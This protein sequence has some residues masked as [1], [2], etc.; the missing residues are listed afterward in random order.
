MYLQRRKVY[1]PLPKTLEEVHA[2]LANFDATTKQHEDFLLV[3]S[4]D[5]NIVIFCTQR[6]LR[7][8]QQC[9]I[10]LMDGTFRS[11]PSLFYQLFTIHGY[12]YQQYVP[13]IF[14]LLPNKQETTYEA[15]FWHIQAYLP[16]DFSPRTVF[17]DFERAIHG[18][19]R[20]VWP[21]SKLFG[22]R[23]HLGQSWFRKMQSLG[24]QRVYRTRSG[25]GAFLRTFFGLPFLKPEDVLD[26]LLE[27]FTPNLPTDDRIL[28]FADYI[29][30]T[31]ALDD[32]LFPPT[33]WAT[34]NAESIRTTNACEAFHSKLNRMFYHSHPH[35]FSLIDALLEVQNFTYL[36]MRNPP[37]VTT[38][39][40]QAVIEEHMKLLDDGNITRYE[41]VQALARK[42]QAL[43]KLA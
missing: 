20:K 25:D 7:Y 27:D 10:I 4:E 9:D 5:D 34:Y 37:K 39:P 41:F 19:V 2:A 12:R 1:P 23:F 40:K 24:L 43:K 13:L 33:M 30:N 29:H 14:C 3:N 16:A 42:F 38:H 17:A 31:Y 21:L 15:A 35:I 32:C 28:R 6:N 22:C 11:C 18:A 36:K 8:L 26:C